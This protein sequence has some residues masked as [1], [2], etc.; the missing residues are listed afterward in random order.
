MVDIKDKNHYKLLGR[1]FAINKKAN[2]DNDP[3]IKSRLFKIISEFKFKYPDI[4]ISDLKEK[5]EVKV[6]NGVFEVISEYQFPQYETP[7][8]EG[9]DELLYLN[10]LC[11]KHYY[12]MFR[13]MV[14]EKF[15][16][17][18][19]YK[20]Y[21]VL[22]IQ[23]NYKA[24]QIFLLFNVEHNKEYIVKVNE[25]SCTHLQGEGGFYSSKQL[26][27]EKL[28]EQLTKEKEESILRVKRL[29]EE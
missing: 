4:D 13:T 1:L 18:K 9:Y 10:L 25:W 6:D 17:I 15:W 12:P 24:E 27:L 28:L 23:E 19:D 20:E 29:M 2:E 22:Y 14:G 8:H 5:Y 7:N 26:M 11:N 16:N 3:S 21:E